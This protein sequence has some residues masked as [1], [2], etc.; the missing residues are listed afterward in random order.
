M[1]NPSVL[2]KEFIEYGKL[3]STFVIDNHT[4]MGGFFGSSL[5][6]HSVQN[7]LVTMEKNNI[8]LIL[9]VPHSA[10]FD[11]LA[12]NTEVELMMRRYPKKIYGYYAFNPN[13]PTETHQIESSF[14]NSSGYVGFKLLPDYHKTPLTSIKYQNVLK[15]ANQNRLLVLCHTWGTAMDGYSYSNMDMVSEIVLTYPNIKFI[16]GHSAQGECDKAIDVATRFPNAY[17]E[18]TD[19]YRLNGMI[20]KMCK[21]AGSQKV[22]FGT[23]LPWYDPAYCIGCILFSEISDDEKIDILN[24]NSINLLNTVINLD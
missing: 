2:A 22:L 13:Y 17:L 11:P 18:L 1:K 20:E 21:I 7:M 24:R 12:A 15:F 4:H 16:M 19:T 8:K 10:L 3:L 5:P 9:C 14:K 23:D 6:N